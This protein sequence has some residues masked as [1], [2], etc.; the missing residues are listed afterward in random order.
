MFERFAEKARTAVAQSAEEAGLRGDRR[1]GTD[2]L[3]LG[4]LHDPD[5]AALL[6]VDVGQ[7]RAQAAALDREALVVIGVDIGNFSPSV[8]PR[9]AWNAQFTS[10]SK[11]VMSRVVVLTAAE[12]ARRIA[13]KHLVLALLERT[14]P[15]PAAAILDG[16][17]VDRDAA[18][19][20]AQLL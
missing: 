15:D 8:S 18:R 11:A 7:A 4:V 5:I 16:L 2:H 6:G 19:A 1:I 13:S 3:L 14:A 10:G 12:K 9:K 17:R 20:K